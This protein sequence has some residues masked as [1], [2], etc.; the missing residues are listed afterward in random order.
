MEESDIVGTWVSGLE[1]SET[2]DSV[3][4]REDSTSGSAATPK[5]G[6][7]MPKGG[8]KRE[9][10]GSDAS[11]ERRRKKRK[12][13]ATLLTS[14]AAIDAQ[15]ESERRES[16]VA[17]SRELSLLEENHQRKSEAMLDSY[18][19]IQDNFS[20]VDDEADTLRSK[21]ARLVSSAVAV[22]AA[23][24]ASA[25][26][27][28]GSSAPAAG[29]AGGHHQRRLWVK[30]RSRAWWDQCNHPN[31]PEAEFRKAFRMGRATFDMICDE[32]GSAVAKEDTMLRAAI[33]VR[34]RVAVCIW[35]LATGEPLRL[36]SK[37]FGLGIS[38]CHKLV[39]EVCT[40]IKT[41]LMPRF[42][43]WPDG[44]PDV[45]LREHLRHPQCDWIHVHHPH[46]DHRPQN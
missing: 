40:A 2:W 1:W 31:F 16:D 17:S 45:K 21:H 46:P 32:L 19:R 11:D 36:V 12:S 8:R 39:L 10:G 20:A 34:Q 33:P 3:R 29:G 9:A 37:R 25:E 23:A 38:T 18:S 7:D 15:E 4:I 41:L 22:A 14:I 43:Q 44:P 28:A 26:G 35:R 13:I 5:A 24:T 27:D 6:S 30:D 42:L